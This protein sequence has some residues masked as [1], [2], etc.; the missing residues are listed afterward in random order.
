MPRI[1]LVEF[2]CDYSNDY[3][4]DFD[5]GI[6][7]ILGFNISDWHEVTDEELNLLKSSHGEEILNRDGIILS[8]YGEINKENI[9]QDYINKIKIKISEH[10]RLQEEHARMLKEQRKKYEEAKKQK[11]LLAEQKKIERAKKLLEK[12]GIKTD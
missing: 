10:K 9:V 5:Q 11:K 6:T 3:D 2:N 4:N 7:D 1:R 12:K 8:V